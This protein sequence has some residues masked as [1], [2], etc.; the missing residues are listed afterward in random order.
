MCLG[1]AHDA[2]A[3]DCLVAN[4]QTG[5]ITSPVAPPTLSGNEGADRLACGVNSRATALNSTAVGSNS[6]AVTPNA[7]ALGQSASVNSVGGSALGSGARSTQVNGTAVGFVARADGVNSTAVGAG[8]SVTLAGTSSV[9]LGAS[10]TAMHNQSIAI[11]NNVTTTG[12]NQIALGLGFQD[13]TVAGIGSHAQ[14]GGI[15]GVVVTDAAGHL[16]SDG[17]A[18][19]TQV[20]TNAADIVSGDLATLASAATAAGLLDTAQTTSITTAYQNADTCLLYTSPSPRD[21][22]KSRMPSSA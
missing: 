15:T 7:T 6:I 16:A 21:R 1:T 13:L 5:I 2:Y 18:L 22:Q 17:G 12:D 4:N 10:A 14:Q 11:G 3:D 8:A 20:N 9:A 19:Q